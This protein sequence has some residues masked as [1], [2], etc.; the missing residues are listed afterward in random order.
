MSSL[1][2]RVLCGGAAARP[3]PTKSLA[4]IVRMP[5]RRGVV[6]LYCGAVDVVDVV[7]AETEDV[8]ILG[9]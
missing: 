8:G 2:S 4:E 9:V 5:E 6:C 7:D 1:V 3:I